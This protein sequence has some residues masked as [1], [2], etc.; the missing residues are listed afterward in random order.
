MLWKIKYDIFNF[1]LAKITLVQ[2]R[3]NLYV[4]DC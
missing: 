1:L 2:Y 4:K 3:L